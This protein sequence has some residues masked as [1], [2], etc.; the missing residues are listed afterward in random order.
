MC[1]FFTEFADLSSSPFT[2]RGN[3]FTA[4]LSD[5]ALPTIDVLVTSVS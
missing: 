4:F 2:G 5:Y 1:L 3:G